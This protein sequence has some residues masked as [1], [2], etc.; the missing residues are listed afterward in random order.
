M[1]LLKLEIG[2]PF[3]SL[4]TGF[5]MNFHDIGQE[6]LNEMSKFQPFC[7]AGLNGTGKSNVLE[8]LAS[9]FYHLEF[10]VAKYRPLIFE[11]YFKRENC[12]PD[13]FLVQYLICDKLEE[14]CNSETLYKVTITKENNKEP[15]MN[16]QSYPFSEKNE[17]QNV[18]LIPPK[19]I[20]APSCRQTIF[21]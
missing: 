18:S 5:S 11:K 13:S 16:I 10:C 8:A 17:I 15:K 14:N 21:T 9:I 19:G 1:K 6:N 4:H 12:T 20:F 2:E 3:R 7:F